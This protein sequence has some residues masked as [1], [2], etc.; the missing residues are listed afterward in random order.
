MTDID[1]EK[2]PFDFE[3]HRQ[4]AVE[5]YSRKID[6]YDEFAEAAKNILAIATR[7]QGSRI[8]EIQ[9]RTKDVKSFGTKAVTP[10]EQNPAEPKYKNPLSDITDLSGIRV[11][12]FFP[13]TVEEVC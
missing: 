11:I 4:R 12:T 8:S 10:S 6:L 2:P 9:F 1:N 13:R 7:N 3:A 5:Q